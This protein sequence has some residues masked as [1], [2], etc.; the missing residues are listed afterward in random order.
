MIKKAPTTLYKRVT[1]K[2]RGAFAS[3]RYCIL[4]IHLHYTYRSR[5]AG[6]H[7]TDSSTT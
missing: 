6:A 1:R 5:L 3:A 2:K 4:R 7:G